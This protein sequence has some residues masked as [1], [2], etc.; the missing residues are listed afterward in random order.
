MEPTAAAAAAEDVYV[1]I[2][3]MN[4][5]YQALSVLCCVSVNLE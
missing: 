1:C 2:S 5:I 3:M 4:L